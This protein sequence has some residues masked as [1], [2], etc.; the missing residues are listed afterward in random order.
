MRKFIV[1]AALLSICAFVQAGFIDVV[2]S[3]PDD[4]TFDATH[5]WDFVPEQQKVWLVENYVVEGPDSVYVSGET[6]TDPDLWMTKAVTNSNNQT[7]TAYSLTLGGNATFVSGSA[8]LLP[9]VSY[10]SGQL[11]FSGGTVNV[12]QTLNMSFI[13]NVPTIGDFSFC[14]TQLAVPEPATMILL[15]LGSLAL[16]GRKK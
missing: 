1:L 11:V 7:W 16:L 14:L 10:S 2:C 15:G 5:T 6:N 12:G 8:D 13:V 3:N 4:P 9:V